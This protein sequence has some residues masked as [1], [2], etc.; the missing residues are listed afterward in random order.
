MQHNSKKY[1]GIFDTMM[2]LMSGEPISLKIHTPSKGEFRAVTEGSSFGV[3]QPSELFSK[4]YLNILNPGE[5]A[6]SNEQSK[7]IA[8]ALGTVP[9]TIISTVPDIADH[10][11]NLI[12]EAKSEIMIFSNFWK[13]SYAAQRIGDALKLLSKR[14]G[15]TNGSC[16]TVKIM[17]DRGSV[18]YSSLEF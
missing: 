14:I 12:V 18:N 3:T 10:Y 4:I 7:P 13:H 11:Y 6:S 8:G 9:L 1:P 17:F 5:H 15:Q 16:V 2:S